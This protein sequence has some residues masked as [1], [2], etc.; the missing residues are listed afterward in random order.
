MK[1]L[2]AILSLFFCMTVTL[3]A[4]QV[5]TTWLSDAVVPGEQTRLFII[6]TDGSIAR[7]D[8]LP[9]VKGASLRW[10]SQG[11]Y[12]RW[13]GSPNQS[14]F[15][16]AIEVTPDEVGTVEIPSLTLQANNGR[17]YTTLPQT[18]TVYPY[19]AIK[20]NTLNLNGTAVPYGM[21]WHVDNQK[22]YV[23]QP[24]RCE[25]K[26]YAPEYILEYTAPAI[27]TSNLAT[28]RFEPT[29][30]EL[31][32]GQPRGSVLYKGVN[33][34]VMTFQSTLF[35]LRAGEVTASGTV[36]ARAALPE[37]DPLIANFIR[38]EVLV[39]MAIPEVKITAQELPPG[40]PSS[41]T[42]AVGNFRISSTTDARDLSANEP[43]TV[44][45]RVTGTGNIHSIACPAL[46]DASN[47]KLYPPNKLDP[48]QNTRSI[49]GTVEFQQM[50]RPVAQTDAIPPF[51][52]T[53]FDPSTQQ[54]KTVT[55]APIPLEWK[56]SAITGTAAGGAAPATPPPAGT[57]P[58]AEMTDIYGL[59][60]ATVMNALTAPAH[61]GWYFLA[62]IPAVILLGM[63]LIRY[64]RKIRKES[65]TARE[66]MRAFRRLAST[67]R[68]ASSTEFLRAAGNLIESYIPPS[69]Q[70]EKMKDILQLRDDRA[71]KPSE[72]SEELPHA[73]RQHMLQ[74]IKKAIAKLPVLMMAAVLALSLAGTTG[75]ASETD[76][77]GV[78]AYEQGEYAKAIDYFSKESGNM[79]LSKA[80]RAYACF[81]IGNSYYRM[82]KPG[83]AALNYRRALELSPY[84]T[85]A[86]YN[87]QFIERKEGAILPANTTEN[88]W[89]TYIR[90]DTLGPISILSGAVMLTF[91]ALLTVTRRHGALLTILATLSGLVTV[92]AVMNYIM[93]PETPESIPADRLLVVT[94]KTPGRHAADMNSPAL[95][96]LPE[97]TPLILRAERGSWYYAS[98]FQN[99]P[100][101]IPRTDAQPL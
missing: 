34:N 94:Q 46:T 72:S 66:R 18:L 59:M 68:Q 25:L 91:L 60:P 67:P 40:A 2:L 14:A 88:Q 20:W 1:K 87:L 9:R 93:Y 42:N 95:I 35:P 101:W 23:H 83:L 24:D 51:E 58:V 55:T 73:E 56:A 84:F 32:R 52:L 38:S 7:Q 63:A 78:K 97:S 47:W 15:L 57:I 54:Y 92:A 62:Y 11:N 76:N 6:L 45:I 12:I 28:W 29:L 27:T 4:Q 98:T 100:V 61:W 65:F 5:V 80:E 85:E 31:L 77:L 64:I 36:T 33:W 19:S 79:N 22:P 10:V 44:K 49:Q 96:T 39:E 37:A 3:M 16:M 75:N 50:M 70:N 69:K 8:P 86:E 74:A 71:F 13:P 48:G 17:T 53:F 26:I 89:L 21:L 81:G 90:H 43:I 30:V 41:F 99:T 82:N